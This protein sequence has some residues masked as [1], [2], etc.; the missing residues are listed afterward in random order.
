MEVAQ[1]QIS[2]LQKAA[3]L[4]IAMG[5]ENASRVMKNLHESE[6]EKITLEIAK[7]KE[8]PAQILHASIEEFYQLLQANQYMMEGGI[9]YAREVLESAWGQKRADDVIKRVEAATE[10]SAFYLIQTVDDNQLQNFLQ[11]EHPQT[12]ALI[13]ANLKPPQAASII[14]NLPEDQQAEIAFRLARMEKT[15]PELIDDVEA[16]L[17]E[18]MGSVLGSG[19]SAAGGAEAVAE[20]L[21]FSSRSAEKNILDNLRERDTN[22]AEEITGLM[23]LF[24]DIV[25]LSDNAIQMILKDIDSKT[26]ALAL[27][28][29]GE[30]LRE[31]VYQNMSERAAE[32]LKDELQYLGPVRVRDVEDAQKKILDVVHDLEDSGEIVLGHGEEEVIE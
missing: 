21:N 19:F 2:S 32:M 25:T 1:P 22:L 5:A 4:I 3:V 24:E 14:S 20:I 27:K 17:R 16:V 28:A 26:L 7:M 12:A 10:M 6:V 31:K 8:I 15:S 30:E 23:F 18:Q 29:T 11:K 13:L 9:K